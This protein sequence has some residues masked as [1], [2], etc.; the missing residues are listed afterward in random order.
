MQ[1]GKIIFL[2][3][4]SS[5]GKTT[6]ERTLQEQLIEPFY[7]TSLDTFIG[8]MPVDKFEHPDGGPVFHNAISMVPHT[9]KAFSD[10]G[11]NT[12]VDHVLVNQIW[13]E[14]CV[15]LLHNYPVLF[16]H[17]TCPLEELRRREKERGDRNIGQAEGQLLQ[18]CP[19]DKYDLIIDTFN[20]SKEECVN[21]IIE[22]LDCPE[23]FTAFKTLWTQHKNM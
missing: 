19:Q 9:A 20:S 23:K 8:M 14:N 5:S 16:V 11:L 13:M 12:I 10:M 1:K 4:V 2:N 15:E 21:K 17:V 18:L 6:I 3:G 7:W 22:L